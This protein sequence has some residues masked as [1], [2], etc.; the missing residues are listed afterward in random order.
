MMQNFTLHPF[1]PL[2]EESEMLVRG[3]VRRYENRISIWFHL[4]TTANC[5][6]PS[7]KDNPCL[8]KRELWKDT[9]FE[10]F[11]TRPDSPEYWELNVA[12][13]GHWDMYRFQDYRKGM[14]REERVHIPTS[15]IFLTDGAFT[16]HC[17]LCLDNLGLENYPLSV[18]MSCVLRHKTDDLSYWALAHNQ[19]H[20]DFHDRRAF[21]LPL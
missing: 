13:E 14:V 21:R 10:L 17:N 20:P 15:R 1:S 8:R 11:L 6:L 2:N 19:V 18:G 9:C 3:G 12:P 7:R 16:L 4:T 5:A